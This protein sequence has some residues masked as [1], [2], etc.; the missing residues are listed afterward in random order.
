MGK[1]SDYNKKGTPDNPKFRIVFLA[2]LALTKMR[3]YLDR[4]ED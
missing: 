1:A 4:N 3:D 2:D